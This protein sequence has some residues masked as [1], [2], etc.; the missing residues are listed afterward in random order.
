MIIYHEYLTDTGL[1]GFHGRMIHSIKSKHQTIKVIETKDLGRMLMIDDVFMTS[2]KDE[3]IYHELITHPAMSGLVNDSVF[4]LG[5]GDGGV[6]REVLKYHEAEIMVA[7]LDPEVVKVCQEFMNI[8]NGALNNPRVSIQYGDALDTLKKLECKF[9]V[10]IL[11]LTDVGTVAD[12]LYSE[13]S[14]RTY[15]QHLNPKGRIALHLGSPIY[16]AEQINEL[17]SR[18]RKTFKHGHLYGSYIPSYGTFWVF[19]V[20]SDH[21]TDAETLA[22]DDLKFYDDILCESYSVAPWR[23]FINHNSW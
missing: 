2:T 4:I 15:K 8:D 18:L 6:A 3:F 21:Y 23:N 9:D 16:H 14:L 7:E 17:T 11:D 13:E 12:G 5:G 20:V 22:P 1:F 19:A 10:M